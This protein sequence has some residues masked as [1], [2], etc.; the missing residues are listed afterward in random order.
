MNNCDEA[1]ELL[2]RLE[3]G[4]YSVKRKL[5]KYSVSLRKY[6]FDG[7]LKSG[8][9]KE[10]DSGVFVLANNEYYSDFVGLELDKGCDIIF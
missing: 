10:Y 5:Q 7:A 1:D 8:L 3:T 9:V 6:E 4:D 2:K